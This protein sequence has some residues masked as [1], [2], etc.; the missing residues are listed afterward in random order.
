M[1]NLLFSVS[2]MLNRWNKKHEQICEVNYYYYLVDRQI[3]RF[4]NLKLLIKFGPPPPRCVQQNLI[5]KIGHVGTLGFCQCI[6][7][8][9]PR[10]PTH[11]AFLEKR[12][13]YIVWTLLEITLELH[14]PRASRGKEGHTL[15]DFLD[16]FEFGLKTF[17]TRPELHGHG[18]AE[19]LR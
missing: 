12:V 8:C 17:S 3:C 16:R 9:L 18:A 5:T 10:A 11:F 7:K 19:I 14:V 15:S 4:L 6:F 2:K 13:R 1:Y